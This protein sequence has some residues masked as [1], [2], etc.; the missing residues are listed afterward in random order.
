MNSE[1]LCGVKPKV[2]LC[3]DATMEAFMS[4]DIDETEWENQ[5]SKAIYY[6]T[7]NENND[8]Q[9]DDFVIHKDDVEC[10]RNLEKFDRKVMSQAI[11]TPDFDKQVDEFIDNYLKSFKR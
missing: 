4:G 6:C 1:F 3:F 10:L 9:I 7:V 2:Y 8:N 11:K 5:S